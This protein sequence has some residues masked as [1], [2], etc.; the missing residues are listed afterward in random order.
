M[1][2]LQSAH[3]HAYGLKRFVDDVGYDVGGCG[4]GCGLMRR[5]VVA[6][7]LNTRV[8]CYTTT[9]NQQPTTTTPPPTQTGSTQ[10][11]QE[12]GR[13]LSV[14]QEIESKLKSSDVAE[15]IRNVS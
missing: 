1:K 7:S 8:R 11:K 5:L 9:T 10:T 15:S 12:D 4:C 13:K 14:A 2:L 6:C 3:V